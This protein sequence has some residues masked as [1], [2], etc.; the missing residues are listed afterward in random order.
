[1]I[2]Q[3]C[4]TGTRR[5]G[6]A[7]LAYLAWNG[8]APPSGLPAPAPLARPTRRQRILAAL[9]ATSHRPWLAPAHRQAGPRPTTARPTP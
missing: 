8:S 3:Q 6:S 7:A 5:N 9:G 2:W 1:M 4:M